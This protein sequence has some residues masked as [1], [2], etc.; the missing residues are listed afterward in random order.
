MVLSCDPTRASPLTQ[1]CPCVPAVPQRPCRGRV[2]GTS[3]SST[4]VLAALRRSAANRPPVSTAAVPKDG[5]EAPPP[6]SGLRS[7]A[8]GDG[9]KVMSNGKENRLA[10]PLE[11]SAGGRSR[12]PSSPFCRW[13]IPPAPGGAS[14]LPPPRRLPLLPDGPRPHRAQEGGSRVGCGGGARG[15]AAPLRSENKAPRLRGSP[16]RPHPHPEAA[17]PLAGRPRPAAARQLLPSSRSLAGRLRLGKCCE[18][19]VGREQRCV[20]L[21]LGARAAPTG[22]VP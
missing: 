6:W 1:R 15:G 7:S 8:C 2:T 22:T 9:N 19:G 4:A 21:R 20:P 12:N 10:H 14:A 13:R 18:Q 11:R 16:R 3:S 17:E 5:R